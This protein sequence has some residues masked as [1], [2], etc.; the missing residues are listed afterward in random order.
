[1][2]YNS[3]KLEKF[4]P[5]SSALTTQLWRAL[6]VASVRLSV[7]QSVWFFWKRNFPHS[8]A[9]RRF[10][11]ALSQWSIKCEWLCEKTE[12]AITSQVYRLLPFDVINYFI[13]IFF[14]KRTWSYT[15]CW[16]SQS[17]TWPNLWL[18]MKNRNCWN[19]L[20]SQIMAIWY[21]HLDLY[22]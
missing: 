20:C 22:V 9:C 3:R 15:S 7:T 1:M 16:T 8:S 4:D 18:C 14:F 6:N 13:F 12:F 11:K 17:K 5:F 19:N 10:N 21:Y 2:I